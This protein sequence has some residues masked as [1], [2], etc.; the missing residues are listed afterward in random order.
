MQEAIWQVTKQLIEE[1]RTRL[2]VLSVV[3]TWVG[4]ATYP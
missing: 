3:L 2:V 1:A 4:W